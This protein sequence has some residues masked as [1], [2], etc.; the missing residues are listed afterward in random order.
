MR[1]ETGDKV[2]IGGFIVK[3]SAPKHVIIRA[4]GPSLTRNGITD[5][6]AD[7]TL[8][9]HGPAG[10]TTVFN[11][12]WRDT[13]QAAIA[14]TGL[15]PINDFESA[16][17]ATLPPGNYTAVVRGN[18]NTTG[19]ALVE[20]YDLNTA[21]ASRLANISTRAFVNMGNNIVIAGFILGNGGGDDNIIV[22]G[23]GPSLSAL[24]VP[25]VL[26]NPTLEL[27]DS[28]GVLLVADD[29]WQ[30]NAAQ[31][32]IITAAGLAP[33][34]NL[35]AAIAATLPPGLYTALLAGLN[36]TSGI[37]LVEV[38][39]RG[40]GQLFTATLN[41]SQEVP[42][43]AS[44]AT[45]SGTVFLNDAQTTITVNLNFAGLAAPA[46]MAHIHGPASPGTNAPVIFPF[47][48][49]P[50]ATSGTIPE[51]TFAIT[52]TQVSQLMN[53][54]FYFNVHNATFPGGEIRGQ[55]SGSAPPPSPT[56]NTVDPNPTTGH[57]VAVTD[58][59]TGHTVADSTPTTPTPT[60][61]GVA[62]APDWVHGELRS[63]DRAGATD[64]V[65][66]DPCHGRPTHLGNLD[67]QSR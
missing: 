39:D 41:G 54:L 57:T 32:A 21:A 19:V 53:G 34:N 29:D 25:N 61:A 31:A 44:T 40:S 24:G 49:V 52:P 2:G 18:G 63:S 13:Q 65:G 3:G 67:D 8:E 11:N 35:E 47:T 64:R 26:A 48:G 56:P 9:L 22:R 51:Q 45:G 59:T 4:L 6:L 33:S 66:G 23:I 12:N 7:P 58:A 16:I 14:A 27:R 36:N 15:A 20:V 62:H 37:G 10:F 17:D 1:V 42:P 38:Y 46:T 55:I 28:N 43:N 30:D 60:T 5:V 50:N